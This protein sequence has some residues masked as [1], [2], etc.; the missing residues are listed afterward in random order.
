M[1]A[2][3][4][5]GQVYRYVVKPWET[6][7]LRRTVEQ[8]LE[9]VYLQ[10]EREKLTDELERRFAALQVASEIAREVEPAG[11]HEA[12]MTR[13]LGKLPGVVPCARAA[14]LVAPPGR[15]A[16]MVLERRGH[17]GEDSLLLERSRLA[18]AA[19]PAAVF[20][21]GVAEL[22]AED[23]LQGGQGFDHHLD[24]A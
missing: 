5:Q 21:G 4:N 3:I 23:R 24:L 20:G 7:E 2:A 1:V 18:E 19:L 12:L 15:A 17:A 6:R 14:A 16:V 13:L 11:D 8:A 10:R 22:L 9:R